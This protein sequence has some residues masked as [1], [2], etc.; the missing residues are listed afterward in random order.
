MPKPTKRVLVVEDEPAWQNLIADLVGEI[1]DALGVRVER[2][3]TGSYHSA[4]ESLRDIPPDLIILD[5]ELE[6]S[7]IAKALLDRVSQ[8]RSQARVII[9]SGVVDPGDVRDFFKDYHI[10]E[11][12]WK[13]TFSPQKFKVALRQKLQEPINLKVRDKASAFLRAAGFEIIDSDAIE[14]P[15]VGRR[16]SHRNLGTLLLRSASLEW[17][18]AGEIPVLC[19]EESQNVSAG[20]LDYLTRGRS[21]RGGSASYAFLFF[22]KRLSRDVVRRLWKIKRE[23]GPIIVPIHT[24][25]LE[26]TQYEPD[27]EPDPAYWKLIALKRQ[28]TS[29]TDPYASLNSVTDPQW[30]F[31]SERRKLVQQLVEDTLSGTNHIAVSGMRRIGKTALLNQLAIAFQ[32]KRIPVAHI[33]CKP[34][35]VQYTHADMLTDI[36]RSW[37]Q[38]LQPLDPDLNVA[39][40]SI[41]FERYTAATASRFEADVRKMTSTMRTRPQSDARLVLVL[42][43]ADHVFPS[44]RSQDE[45]YHEYCTLAQVLKS[46]L[47]APGRTSAMTLVVAV[48]HPLIHTVDRFPYKK[49]LQN[50]LYG[51]FQLAPVDLLARG[52]WA[53]M[54]QTIGALVGLEYTTQGLD[55]LWDQTAGHPEIT[56]RVCSCVVELRDEDHIPNRIGVA[57]IRNALGR[58]L[59][60]PLEQGYYLRRTFWDDE[61]SPDLESEHRLLQAIAREGQLSKD[62]MIEEQLRSYQKYIQR[63]RGQPALE[64]ELDAERARLA[65][66]LGHLVDLGILRDLGQGMYGILLSIYRDWIRTEILGLEVSRE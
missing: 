34:L 35:S 6:G 9:L 37:I 5:N 45:Q 56:R 38:S 29:L 15:A 66:A 30:F 58:F 60:R 18:D 43:E 19:L 54:V 28:W 24:A 25:E 10:D 41:S 63:R 32:E 61:K 22:H 20:D 42:D 14:V 44:A 47:E 17:H 62:I 8:E 65:V 4:I 31:G 21:K 36:V 13:G 64:D 52:D 46:V 49:N 50:P 11:F 2:V 27:S 26:Q 39:L 40:G 57:H 33:V 55:L 1:A 16:V 51:R 53:D 7:L 12:F 59:K 23:G 3:T 48:E